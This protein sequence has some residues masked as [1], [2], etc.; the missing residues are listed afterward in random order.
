M[1]S[2]H[3]QILLQIRILRSNCISTVD[4]PLGLMPSSDRALKEQHKHR[5]ILMNDKTTAGP[6]IAPNTGTNAPKFPALATKSWKLVAKLATRIL[7]HTLPEDLMNFWKSVNLNPWQW[8]AFKH[9]SFRKSALAPLQKSVARCHLGF[10]VVTLY[11]A[12]SSVPSPYIWQS[13][14]TMSYNGLHLSQLWRKH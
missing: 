6:K 10:Q 14:S 4:A 2:V 3:F 13:E 7:H 8:W 9:V 1:S 5:E 11:M 12:P